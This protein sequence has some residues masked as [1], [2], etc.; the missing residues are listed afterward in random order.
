MT[1]TKTTNGI[2]N[3]ITTDG[4]KF[5]AK[6]SKAAIGIEYHINEYENVQEEN[7]DWD[8]PIQNFEEYIT[9][10]NEK[11]FLGSRIVIERI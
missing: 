5:I 8:M 2:E 6:G 7:A 1:Y 4:F 11:G 3:V 10:L 9:E